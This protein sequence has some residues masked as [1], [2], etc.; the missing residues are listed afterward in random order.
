[1]RISRYQR[2][3]AFPSGKVIASETR[4]VDGDSAALFR[5]LPPDDLVRF[6]FIHSTA[7]ETYYYAPDVAV[8]RSDAFTRSHCFALIPAPGKER[9]RVGLA[10]AP[11]AADTLPDV[12]GA[13]WIDRATAALVSM[14][15]RY[16][17]VPSGVPADTLIGGRI[18]FQRLSSGQWVISHWQLR[19]PLE[20]AQHRNW[21]KARD[22][23][24]AYYYTLIQYREEGGD[25]LS[26]GAKQPNP[27]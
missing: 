14:E 7:G 3:L 26:A 24:G 21:G 10:F 2:D 18:D 1:V 6:G 13:L 11:L 8:L 20:V 25:L 17:H 12:R 5:S 9:G 4:D 23:S 22:D 19:L 27:P 16:A 15:F